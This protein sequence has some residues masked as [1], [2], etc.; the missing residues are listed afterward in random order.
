M[1]PLLPAGTMGGQLYTAPLPIVQL[2]LQVSPLPGS[3]DCEEFFYDPSPD[4][5]N[6]PI[7]VVCRFFL[8]QGHDILVLNC[9]DITEFQAARESGATLHPLN[10]LPPC[11]FTEGYKKLQESAIAVARI[12]AA[13]P[14][15]VEPADPA[16]PEEHVAF[17]TPLFECYTDI[18]LVSLY[19]HSKAPSLKQGPLL[20]VGTTVSHPPMLANAPVG[21]PPVGA[22]VSLPPFG[23]GLSNHHVNLTLKDS[24]FRRLFHPPFWLASH[25]MGGTLPNCLITMVNLSWS[26]PFGMGGPLSHW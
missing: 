12:A 4:V 24:S 17:R 25:I 21:L 15:A 5:C 10:G 8:A 20:F 2:V 3:T 11:V 18:P 23:A 14:E 16:V 19:V 1:E 6:G 13:K 7:T 26:L 9:P 22:P